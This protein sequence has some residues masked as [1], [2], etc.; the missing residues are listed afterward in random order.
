[1]KCTRNVKFLGWAEGYDMFEEFRKVLF[2]SV[3]R[4]KGKE[5]GDEIRKGSRD[6]IILGLTFTYSFSK[7]LLST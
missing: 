3:E 5:A 4:S 1:M 2:E 7:Y 6:Q